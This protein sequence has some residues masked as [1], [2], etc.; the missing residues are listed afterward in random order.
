[1]VIDDDEAVRKL[2]E[3]IVVE[4]VIWGGFDPPG[5][6][7][8]E[9]KIDRVEVGLV[10][11]MPT[12]PLISILTFSVMTLPE[13]L[14]EKAKYPP[15]PEDPYAPLIMARVRSVSPKR[16]ELPLLSAP[17]RLDC[18]NIEAPSTVDPAVSAAVTIKGRFGAVVPMPTLPP[19]GL[20]NTGYTDARLA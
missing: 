3:M 12:L 9:P 7:S 18:T 14:V 20:S 10:R 15:S 2:P 13:V 11:P 5:A 6:R 8:R 1:M 17:P 19:F 4:A 16:M